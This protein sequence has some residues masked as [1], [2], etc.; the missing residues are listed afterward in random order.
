MSI[1]KGEEKEAN[2]GFEVVGAVLR[3]ES[4]SYILEDISCHNVI[5]IGGY[6]MSQCHIYVIFT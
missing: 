4:E 5:Y 6:I 1:R 3:R 2:K